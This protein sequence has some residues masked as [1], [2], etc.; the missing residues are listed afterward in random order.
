MHVTI[1]NVY[2]NV[3][4]GW[5]VRKRQMTFDVKGSFWY[6]PS[7]DWNTVCGFLLQNWVIIII[8]TFIRKK[9]ITCVNK[10]Q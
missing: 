10:K 2:L 7:E 1:D 5:G 9:N 3:W 4:V 8:I 6:A